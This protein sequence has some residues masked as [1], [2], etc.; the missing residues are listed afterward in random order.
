MVELPSCINCLELLE[1][2]ISGLLTVLCNHSFH[3]DCSTRW[4]NEINCVVCLSCSTK[5]NKCYNCGGEE[6]LWICLI[7]GL[8]GCSRYHNKH[9]QSHFLDTKHAFALELETQ[10]VWDYIS[11]N[12]VHKYIKQDNGLLIQMPHGLKNDTLCNQITD[13]EQLNKIQLVMLEYEYLMHIQLETQKQYFEGTINNLEKE[14][15]ITISQ[16]E[17]DYAKLS[18]QKQKLIDHI[19]EIE[20]EKNDLI[21]NSVEIENKLTKMKEE[22]ETIKNTNE[23]SKGLE[24]D[25][26]D[27]INQVENILNEQKNKKKR[28]W[29]PT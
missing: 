12:Y 26:N 18:K 15:V 16:I 2:S 6:N 8:I 5:L 20:N 13:K 24:K 27:K 19:Q 1:A 21:Q 10:R 11:D 25:Y 23:K 22:I 3:C 28:P 4:K 7:C 17:R 29:C 14:K 9:S